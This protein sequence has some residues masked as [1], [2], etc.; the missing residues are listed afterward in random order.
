MYTLIKVSMYFLKFLN[1][2][3]I[4]PFISLGSYGICL[5]DLVMNDENS[6]LSSNRG[7]SINK[8]F[9]SSVKIETWEVIETKSS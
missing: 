6:S 4:L 9:M 1:I 5:M 2:V 7:I 3:V 8:I